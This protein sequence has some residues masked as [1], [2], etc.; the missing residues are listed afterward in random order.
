MPL[1][2][3]QLKVTEILL[4]HQ[5]LTQLSFALWEVCYN[6][7]GLFLTLEEDSET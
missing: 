7:E 3:L 5:E 2:P 6:E 1:A 4:V